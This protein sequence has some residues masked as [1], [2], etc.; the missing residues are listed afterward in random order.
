MSRLT[1]QGEE[2]RKRHDLALEKVQRAKDE[3][4][5][6][7]T[8]KVKIEDELMSIA[9]NPSKWWNWCVPEDKKKRDGKKFFDHLIW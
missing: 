7:K 3:W 1:D 5:K 9:W 6:S 8:Q 4:N 2:E